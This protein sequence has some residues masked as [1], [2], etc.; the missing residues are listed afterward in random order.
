DDPRCVLACA[1]FG[2]WTLLSPESGLHVLV[3]QD[4]RRNTLRHRVRVTVAPCPNEPAPEDPA[5]RLKGALQACRAVEGD[6]TRVVRRYSDEPSPLVRDAVR[7]WRTGRVDRVFAGDFDLLPAD[8][9]GAGR[10]RGAAASPLL[11]PPS[12]SAARRSPPARVPR[13]RPRVPSAFAARRR[14]RARRATVPPRNGYR[15]STGVVR[16]AHPC[17]DFCQ[18]PRRP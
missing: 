4:A 18:D 11:A 6:P 2:A 7:G 16:R 5:A 3:G 15:A 1:G 12:P 8:G 10:G 9:A 17:C 13:R 14:R